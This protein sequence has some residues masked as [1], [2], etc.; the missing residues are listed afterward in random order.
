[1]WNIG[2]LDVSDVAW[3]DTQ[4]LAGIQGCFWPL[5]EDQPGQT[6]VWQMRHLIQVF[7]LG[8]LLTQS[9]SSPANPICIF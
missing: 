3:Q 9:N 6:R 5:E 1:M 4:V 7:L 8:V 2:Y